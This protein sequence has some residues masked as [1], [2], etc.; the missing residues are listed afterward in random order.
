MPQGTV[1][2]SVFFVRDHI[3]VT[4][5]SKRWGM[6]EGGGGEVEAQNGVA[7]KLFGTS[8]RIGR[9][10]DIQTTVIMDAKTIELR[11]NKI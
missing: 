6:G 4:Q 1:P 3:R 5:V 8:H 7:M 2:I 10:N 9:E 11:A